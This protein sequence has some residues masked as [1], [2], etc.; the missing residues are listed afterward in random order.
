MKKLLILTL[1][2]LSLALFMLF[3]SVFGLLVYKSNGYDW[4]WL[5]LPFIDSGVQIARTRDTHQLL[6][7]KL[8]LID[9]MEVSVYTTMDNKLVLQLTDLGSCN[10]D[11]SAHLKID[12][13]ESVPVTFNC[14]EQHQLRYSKIVRRLSRAQLNMNGSALEIDFSSW[15]IADLQKDQFKQLHPEYFKRL[16]EDV[17]Y[18]WSRD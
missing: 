3:G 4:E 2:L 17:E 10:S 8:Y 11:A 14:D 1:S 5:G 6:L 15:N 13:L 16:G 18:P 9:S 7:R 12:E